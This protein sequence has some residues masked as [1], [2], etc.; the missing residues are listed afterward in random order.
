[1]VT[2]SKVIATGKNQASV[3]ISF[4]SQVEPILHNSS[5]HRAPGPKG[6]AMTQPF[7]N[8]FCLLTTVFCLAPA[9]LNAADSLNR[10]NF[11]SDANFEL[12]VNKSKNIRLG[13]TKIHTQSAFVSLAHGLVGNCDGIEIIFLPKPI[14]K[15]DLA[16]IEKNDAANLKKQTYAALVLFLNKQNKIFQANLSYVVPG[17]SVV[18]TV[19]WKPEDLKKYFSDVTITKK[20]VHLKSSGSYSET[21]PAQEVLTMRWAVNLNLPVIHEIKR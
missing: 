10:T 15:N 13:S 16:D 14:V 4:N 20:M 8:Y 18:R 5:Y 21:D 12:T 1:L 11:Q 9:P 3:I 7:K 17:T 2:T 19:A 6:I